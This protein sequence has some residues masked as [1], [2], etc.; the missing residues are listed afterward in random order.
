MNDDIVNKATRFAEL[1]QK[2]RPIILYNIWDA[3]SA[4]T[5]RDAGARAIATGSWSVAAAQGYPDGHKI[6]LDLV[7]MVV[8]R[9]VQ[10][11]D[12][13]VTVDFE[14]AYAEAPEEA[15]TNVARIVRLGAIG[16]NFEDQ[17]VGQGGLH[18]VERQMQR[19]RAIR[20]MADD[21]KVPLF[22]NART[23]LFLNAPEASEHA[24]LV[25]EAKERAAAYA[26]AGASA[27]F[28]PGLVD[29][30]LIADVCASTALPVNV[31]MLGAAMSLA[32]VA[33]L[34]VARVSYGPGP[35][36]TTMAALAECARA[37]YA[38]PN[39]QR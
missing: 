33:E 23:D 20:A 35:F 30:K 8:D 37:I 34:G 1:H 12:L 29:E 2:G 7:E 14:G 4:K 10:S 38:K 21:L 9:I 11:V 32:R 6:P 3:A 17:I 15:A 26:E 16:I 39:P 18:P 22:I 19:I 36:R 5:V 13:P 24:A 25:S 31:M 27:F 28:V